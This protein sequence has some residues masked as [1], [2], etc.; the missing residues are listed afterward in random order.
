M[1]QANIPNITPSITISRD[2]ALN[3]LLASIAIEE[4]GMGH[5][6]N[7][8]AEKIQYALVHYRVS[9]FQLPSVNYLQL[10]VA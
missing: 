6:I 9:A 4:L 2:D 3:L 10:T 1:S 7:A 5:V 8:E